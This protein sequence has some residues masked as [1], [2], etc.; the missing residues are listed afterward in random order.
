MDDDQYKEKNEYEYGNLVHSDHEDIVTEKSHDTRLLKVLRLMETNGSNLRSITLHRPNIGTP[1]K[2]PKRSN[3][4]QKINNVFGIY[5]YFTNDDLTTSYMSL[6]KLAVQSQRDICFITAI[7]NDE[8]N[9]I[10]RKRDDDPN[11]KTMA[12]TT[13]RWMR[14]FP[15]IKDAVLVLEECSKADKVSIGERSFKRLHVHILTVLNKDEQAQVKKELLR[16][17]IIRGANVK[18]T[19]LEKRPYTEWDEVDEETL[20]AIPLKGEALGTEN[21]GS[22]Y[23]T[24]ENGQ[25]LVCRELP[26]CLRA[27]DYMSKALHRNIGRGRNY[28]L[29][30]LHGK[31]QLHEELYKKGT[32][33]LKEIKS[34]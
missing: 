31:R 23:V 9:H 20:G 19:W 3:H 33:I 17:K 13:A 26:L 12:T 1:L 16:G 32:A 30:G 22:T 18:T 14:P 7:F 24:T 10:L 28:A 8:A 15:Y 6:Y 27:A 2:D 25:K 11:A 34:L 29:L 5:P 4:Q 21:W